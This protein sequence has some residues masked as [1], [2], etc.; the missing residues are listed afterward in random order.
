MFSADALEAPGSLNWDIPFSNQPTIPKTLEGS[1]VNCEVKRFDCLYNA[2]GEIITVSAGQSIKAKNKSQYEESALVFTRFWSRSDEVQSTSLEVKSPYMK[3]AMKATIPEYKSFDIRIKHITIYNQPRCLFHY[4]EELT[5]YGSVLETQDPQAAEHVHF[6][7][8][9]MWEEL[10]VQ[11]VDFF[12]GV[13]MASEGKRPSLECSNLWMAFRPGDLVYVRKDTTSAT[14]HDRLFR[15]G[16]MSQNYDGSWGMGG[17]YRRYSNGRVSSAPFNYRVSQYSG[18]RA[19][20]DLPAVSLRYHSD[21]VAIKERLTARGRKYASLQR[22]KLLR[23]DGVAQLAKEN[24]LIQGCFMAD[25]QGEA[26]DEDSDEDSDA[27]S[28]EEVAESDI[29]EEETDRAE[30]NRH[31][32]MD[33][34]EYAICDYEIRGYCL[35]HNQWGKFAVELISDPK[36]EPEVF[37]GLI[38]AEDCK[39]QLLSL[40]SVHNDERMNFDDLVRGKGKGL[41]FLLYGEPGVGKTLTA[42]IAI[43]S[44]FLSSRD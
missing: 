34:N 7:L 4:R 17:W 10:T 15:F 13:E 5:A 8:Q 42:G 19:L 31:S 28:G 22:R 26:A 38:L 30:N 23:Y 29:Y 16:S 21:A 37:D 35:R 36:F 12:V 6:L 33:A 32:P 2:D 20:Q 27:G 9:Y 41:I 18:H 11:T 1:G 3:A 40:V 24:V 43:P 25:P 39:Q 44:K 14:Q